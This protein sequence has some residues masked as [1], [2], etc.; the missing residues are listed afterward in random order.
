[1]NIWI[2]RP[3]RSSLGLGV[4]LLGLAFYRRWQGRPVSQSTADS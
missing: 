3:W 1:V 2:E 4:I